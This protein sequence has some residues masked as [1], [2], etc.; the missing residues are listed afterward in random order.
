MI[1]IRRGKMVPSWGVL[2]L[3]GACLR[4]PNPPPRL[5][6]PTPAPTPRILQEDVPPPQRLEVEVRDFKATDTAD[7][8]GVTVTGTIVNKGNR[9]TVQV[10]AVVEAFNAAGELVARLPAVP[11]TMVIAPYGGSTSFRAALDF[12]PDVVRYHVEVVAR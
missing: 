10:V 8:A 5:L 3:L 7:G 4:A 2:C 12:S 11:E 6:A 9:A 1:A